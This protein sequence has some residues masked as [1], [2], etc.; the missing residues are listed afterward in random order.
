MRQRIIHP[1]QG[2][3]DDHLKW[4]LSLF[5]ADPECFC[6][7]QD[8]LHTDAVRNTH[9]VQWVRPDGTE[10]FHLVLKRHRGMNG[11]NI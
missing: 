8:I 5:E 2:Y 3:E 7:G 4:R 9:V 11:A 6:C 1:I 10:E